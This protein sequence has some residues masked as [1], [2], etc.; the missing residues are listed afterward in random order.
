MRAKK[1]KLMGANVTKSELMAA[2][3]LKLKALDD[4][5]GP[6]LQQLP[7]L[8]TVIGNADAKNLPR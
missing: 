4:V 3:L 7:I 6:I 1:D 2:L 5:T 8:P